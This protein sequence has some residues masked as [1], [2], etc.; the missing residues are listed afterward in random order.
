MYII[1]LKLI[2]CVCTEI[3][4]HHNSIFDIS[5]L[6]GG[7][8]IVRFFFF[9]FFLIHFPS[10]CISS[11][12]VTT[13]TH[14]TLLHY[15]IA[16]PNRWQPRETCLLVYGMSHAHVAWGN[17]IG[18]ATVSNVWMSTRKMRVSGGKYKIASESV[19][20][21]SLWCHGYME[22]SRS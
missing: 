13:A 4:C 18:I 8:K 19:V 5:W 14:T 20:G 9:F 10:A 16:I 6:P 3:E 7:T 1:K 21:G 11:V 17:S 2:W 22:C 15:H 12:A